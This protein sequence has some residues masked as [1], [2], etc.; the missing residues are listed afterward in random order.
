VER[1]HRTTAA[2][3]WVAGRK[4][5]HAVLG[6]I[7]AGLSPFSYV[8]IFPQDEHERLLIDRLAEAGVH[9]DRQT[10][11]LGFEQTPDRVVAHLQGA[12][13]VAETCEA[14]Y[15]AGCDGAHSTVRE[16]LGIGFPGGAYAHLFYVADVEARGETMNGEL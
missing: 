1:G 7:G 9:V 12:D 11:L 16:A 15:L 14:A 6:E 4:A 8:L 10:E 3:L 13:G 2:N 5:A